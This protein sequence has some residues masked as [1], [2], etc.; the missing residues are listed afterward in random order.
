M[1]NNTLNLLKNTKVTFTPGQ[2][3]KDTLTSTK[4][5]PTKCNAHTGKCYQCEGV[6]CMRKNFCYPLTCTLCSQ[7]YV[8]ESSRFYR[9]RMWEHFK[10]VSSGNRDTAMGGH[11]QDSHAGD[12]TPDVPFEHKVLRSCRDYPDR[13]L[14]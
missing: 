1:L 13:L 6:D 7:T 8:S 3:L 12:E 4:L 10:S 11:Y 2:K 9:N 5:K 14:W